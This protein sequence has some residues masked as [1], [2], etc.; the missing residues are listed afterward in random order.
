MPG[1]EGY[2]QE[3]RPIRLDTPLGEDI[4]LLEQFAGFEAI[5][6]QYSFQLDAVSTNPSLPL[7]DLLQ[8]PVVVSLRMVSDE[9]RFFHGIVNRA[10]QGERS[11]GLT[12]YRLEIVPWTW[13]LSL[14]TDCRI[15]EDK[16][17]P[18]I[19]EAIFKDQGFT[20]YELHLHG[21][22]QPREYC[23]QYRENSLNFVSRLMEEEGIF[24]FFEH[25][26]DKH[27]LILA[28]A[29]SGFEPCPDNPT[30]RYG[31][32]P[33]PGQ[34]DDLMLTLTREHAVRSRTVSLT[35]YDFQKPKVSLDVRASNA[36]FDLYDYP[37]YYL[38]RDLGERYAK[39]RLEEHEATRISISGSTNCRHFVAGYRFNLNDTLANSTEPYVL[40]SV[41]HSAV[42]NSYRSDRTESFVYENHFQAFPA[43]TPFRPARLAHK[44]IVQ[45]TQTAVVDGPSGEEIFVDKYGR[46]KVHFYW[47]REDKSS[48]WVRVSQTWAGKT[49]GGIQI[50]RI[51]QEVVVDF[52]EGDP[53]RPLVIGRVYNAEQMPPYTLP[54]DQ[55]I[56]GLKSR[57][58]KEGSPDNYNELIFEDKKGEEFIRIHAEKD[59][60]DYVEKKSYEYVGE[61]RHLIVDG[62]QAEQVKGDKHLTVKG[63]QNESVGSASLS[64]GGDKHS[65]IGKLYA[66]EAGQEIHIKSGMKLIIEAGVQLSLKAAG[67]FVDIGPSGVTIQGIMVLINSGGSAGSGSGASPSQPKDPQKAS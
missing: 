32:A 37:G 46:I 34:E 56:S 58:T 13:F 63:A 4:L 22:Y 6:Q 27:K 2:S 36:R 25:T 17:A 21:N 16:T 51:G 15:F 47:D 49:W 26:R 1:P 41:A 24:Y 23:V 62:S 9:A 54:A 61:D 38:T 65:K 5:S 10:T 43:D 7:E 45:G 53:D 50:P 11:Q 40:F 19:I 52:L 48:C 12:S 18:Q 28:D 8:K 44:P 60:H 66:M 64:V 30:V 35:D 29:I 3:D 20:D 42:A 57:S 31:V 33:A 14:I 39:I 59:Q 55:T 67:G